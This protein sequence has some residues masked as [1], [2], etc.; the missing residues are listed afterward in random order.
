MNPGAEPRP[1]PA[2][3]S[4]DAG[5]RLI[6][7][8]V[9]LYPAAVRGPFGDELIDLTRQRWLDARRRG[10][11]SGSLW[12]IREGGPL[13]FGAAKERFDRR[14]DGNGLSN[15]GGPSREPRWGDGMSELGWVLREMGRNSRFT[16]SLVLVLTL[17]LGL[18]GSVFAFVDGVLLKPLRYAESERLAAIWASRPA[19]GLER[20]P[21]TQW[22][23]QQVMDHPD[24]F[25][26]VG[27]F[28]QQRSAMQLPDG[29]I[30]IGF[31]WLTTSLHD[32][33][34]VQPVLGR[35][36][37]KEEQGELVVLLDHGF[38]QRQ[39]GGDPDI[40]GQTVRI[41]Q[42]AWTVVGVLPPN[43]PL[44]LPARGRIPQQTDV[45]SIMWVD[46]SDPDAN[47]AWIRTVARLAPGVTVDEASTL[48]DRI[49]DDA[50]GQ[51]ADREEARFRFTMDPLRE[52]FTA[53]ISRK[54]WLL[55]AGT[56][57]L[58]LAA[59]ANAGNLLVLHHERR[60]QRTA[61]RLALGASRRR[62]ATNTW[63]EA[64]VLALVSLALAVPLGQFVL[65]ALVSCSPTDIPRL[66]GVR[67]DL[68][69]YGFMTLAA[70]VSTVLMGLLSAFW[71][72]RVPV[73]AVIRKS[74]SGAAS[75]SGARLVSVEV[76]FAVPLLIVGAL[77]ARSAQA[78]TAID[79]GFD[80][81]DAVLV[82]TALPN[83]EI[84]RV[85]LAGILNAFQDQLRALPGVESVGSANI[86]PLAGGAF[87]GPVG[88]GLV[89]LERADALEGDYRFA[90][91]GYLESVGVGLVNGSW[92]HSTDGGNVVA[93][94]AS[95]AARLW[96]GQD[97][98]GRT[99]AARPLGDAREDFRVAAVVTATRHE[100]IRDEGRPTVYFMSPEYTLPY[101][102]AVVRGR[103]DAASIFP[104]ARAAGRATH[105]DFL[106][107]EA[108]NLNEVVA[109]ASALDRWLVTMV[110]ALALGASL[111]TGVG[112]YAVV[113]QFISGYKPSLGIRRALGAR[114]VHLLSLVLRKVAVIVGIG[115]AL[116]LLLA[117]GASTYV[118][119]ELVGVGSTDPLTWAAAAVVLLALALT[120]VAMPTR[121]AIAVS[122]MDVLRD[123]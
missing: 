90:T 120:A 50:R 24:V 34:D 93:V 7:W 108:R 6:A 104:L 76:A 39:F 110:I 65:T 10:L 48:L 41:A 20:V 85:E 115:L 11:T 107:A 47:S 1:D 54:L 52:D 45:W 111:I 40:L 69:A 97:P 23:I 2:P 55:F 60:R 37:T 77:L 70:G 103:V 114:A 81:E 57:V 26:S 72:R 96:P 73:D 53:G 59:V 28:T 113:G 18:S 17:A 44:E 58:L 30:E 56:V 16:L 112:L 118:R 75:W 74:R 121:S 123:E 91:P 95:L 92:P 15:P 32:V 82:R 43:T 31:G 35:T 87:T 78:L 27:G 8:L 88:A 51:F 79:P 3:P 102:S 94:D 86:V 9:S 117:A 33:L 25:E 38:W 80:A 66:D 4:R 71:N 62:L 101:M 84:S 100:T 36:F 99:L 119:S 42:Q 12:W 106:V 19:E 46:G 98:V 13:A 29:A 89:D 64:T 116:G 22:D 68:R 14:R 61:I 122:P 83:H 109:S 21:L 67:F 5:S 105:P 63:L 49:A